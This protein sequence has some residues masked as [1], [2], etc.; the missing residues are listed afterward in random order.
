MSMSNLGN[1]LAALTSTN[2]SSTGFITSTS[3]DKT[4]SIGRGFHH[5]SLHGHSLHAEANV[6]EKVSIL[7]DSARE[8]AAVNLIDLREAAVSALDV[9]SEAAG[10]AYDDNNNNNSN[11][12]VRMWKSP[13]FMGGLLSQHNLSYERGMATSQQ[14]KEMDDEIEKMLRLIG[15]MVM[16]IPPKE[17]VQGDYGG[18]GN[19]HPIVLASLQIIEYLLRRYE[20]H[21]RPNTASMLLQT[22]LPL[23]VCYPTSNTATI[24]S[25]IVALVDLQ[26]LPTFT[27]LRPY[28]ARGAPPLSRAG[29]AK[30]VAKDDAL[31][32]VIA[33]IGKVGR[34]VCVVE[35]EEMRNEM[36]VDGQESGGGACVVRRG[37]STLISFSASILVEALYHQ[38]KSQEGSVKSGGVITTGVQESMVRKILPLV[39]AAL[40]SGAD[41]GDDAATMYCPEW[42]E[43]G[44]LLASTLA[45]LSPLNDTVK[46]ALCNSAAEGMPISSLVGG[47]KLSFNEVL[48][49]SSSLSVEEVDDATSAI[50]TLITIM[51]SSAVVDKK[52]KDDDDDWDYY[53]PM[54]PP[55]KNRRSNIVDYMGVDIASST[56]KILS[57]NSSSISVAIG[58]ILESIYGDSD[59]DDEDSSDHDILDRMA[60]FVASLVM[61]AFHR[62]EKEGKK[63][64]MA[65]DGKNK[66]KGDEKFKADRD[67]IMLLRLIKEP[68]LARLWNFNQS[69]LIAAVSV[70]LV[71]SFN[72]LHQGLSEKSSSAVLTE[73]YKS[74]LKALSEVNSSVRDQGVAYAINTIPEGRRQESRLALLLER[75]AASLQ[76][77]KSS[78]KKDSRV[79]EADNAVSSLLPLRVA[80]EHGDSK[81]RLDAVVRLNEQIYNESSDGSVD[82]DAEM[83]QAL[84]RRLCTEDDPEV[85]VVAGEILLSQLRVLKGNENGMDLDEPP[86]LLASLLDDLESLAKKA[87]SALLHWTFIG[88]D[89]TWS[90]LSSLEAFKQGGKSEQNSIVLESP[91]TSCIGICGVVAKLIGDEI[92]VESDMDAED[93]DLDQLTQLY[94]KLFL[95]VGAH[96]NGMTATDNDDS[97]LTTKVAEVASEELLS[98]AKDGSVSTSVEEF[99]TSS[100]IAEYVLEQ[101]YSKKSFDAPALLQNRFVWL[102]L[103][104]HSEL[105][106]KLSSRVDAAYRVID[107]IVFQMNSY[108]KESTKSESFEMEARFLLQNCDN[109]LPVLKS[110]DLDGFGN[111]I[112]KLASSSSPVSVESISKPAIASQ[113]TSNASKMNVAPDLVR[114]VHACLRSEASKEG[115]VHILSTA[116]AALEGGK[117]SNE[118]AIECIVPAFALLSHH[119]RE[120]RESLLEMLE[121]I[122]LA[123]KD[124][125]VSLIYDKVTDKSSPLRSSLLM[126]GVGTLPQA[127]S[128]IVLSFAQ[129][130]D[131]QSFFIKQCKFCALSEDNEIIDG[132]CQA[133]AVILSA[134]ERS[135][136]RVFPLA[137]R[138]ELG[139]RDLFQSFLRLNADEFV[140]NPS[141]CRL[142]D[143]VATM[144]K[145]VLV[146]TMQVEGDGMSIQ[147]SVGPSSSGRRS[148]SYSIGASDSFSV[149]EPYPASMLEAILEALGS[150]SSPLMLSDSVVQQ[151]VGRQSWINGVFPKL[152]SKSK[153]AVASALLT[154]RTQHENEIAG[155]ALLSLPMTAPDLVHLLDNL[156][157]SEDSQAAVVFI[158]DCVREKSDLGKVSDISKLSSK[159]FDQLL[160]LSS[161]DNNEGDSGGRDY[162]RVSILQTLLGI[163]QQY[164][165]QISDLSADDGKKRRKRSRS[166][167]DV[168][169][170]KSLATQ[171]NMLVGIVG[172]N[173]STINPLHSGRGRSLALS[174]L[175]CLCEESPSTVSS[176]LLPALMS[177]AGKH[178]SN[179]KG[180]PA[181]D[182]VGVDSRVLA[183]A[184]AAIIPAYCAHAKSA[185]LSLFSLIESFVGK[186]IVPENGNG[187]LRTHLIDPF[188]NAL[189]LL[190]TKEDSIDAIA[191]LA[192][193]VLALQ[194]FDLNNEAQTTG[195]DE[196]NSAKLNCHVLATSPSGIKV[197]IS[198]LLL[199]YAEQ[200]MAVICGASSFSTDESSS[201]LKACMSEVASLAL[202]GSNIGDNIPSSYSDCSVSQQRSILYLAICLL[203]MVRDVTGTN[204]VKRLLRKSQGD[205]AD[206]SLRLW[207]ELLQAHMHALRAHAKLAGEGELRRKEQKFWTAVPVAISECLENIQGLLPV[208]HFL[209]SVSSTLA[210]ESTDTYMRKKT[211]RLLADRVA[212]VSLD[213]AEASLFLEMVPELVAQVGTAQPSVASDDE[214]AVAALK[215]NI[216][217]QQG[218]LV[219]LESF[220]RSLCP[221]SEKSKLTSKAADAFVPALES[222]TKLFSGTA[223]SWSKE[224][225]EDD[226]EMLG[227]KDAEC[228]LLSSSS[229]C[230]ASLV[231]VLKARCLPLLPS[232][233]KP[234]ISSLK[235][236]NLLVENIE[237]QAESSESMLQLAILRLLETLAEN[238]PQFL[239]P[240]LPLIFSNNA[241]PS[242]ALR[243]GDHSLKEATER[244]ES[245]LASK[246]PIRQ[247]TPALSKALSN[248]L[249]NSDD[250]DSNDWEEACSILGVI[251]ASVGTS[252][253]SELPPVIG[254]IFN[255]L[256]AAYSYEGGDECKSRLLSDANKV[257]LSLV[258]KL[259]ESQLRQLYARLREWRGDIKEDDDNSEQSC[260]R[261]VAFW[262]LS[263]A[264]SKSLRSIFLPCLTS[265]LTDV[266]DELEIAVSLLCQRPKHDGSK[267]RR[268]DEDSD[269]DSSVDDNSE[270][271]PLQ[272]LLLCLESALKAD[273]HEG[274]DWTRGDDNQRYNMILSHLGKLLMVHVPKDLPVSSDLS[275]KEDAVTSSYQKLVEGQGTLEH[276][277]VAGCLTALATAAG[278]EQLWKPLNFAVLEACSHKRS[279]VRRAGIS[280][281]LSIIET[282]GEEYMV[283]LPECLPVLSELLEDGDEEI[284]GMAKECVRQGEELLGESLE[285]SLR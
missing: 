155:A 284:A 244:V 166:H 253:R 211:V 62:I 17:L 78:S 38:S 122:N 172:G 45:L 121:R 44:R 115:I 120:V 263:A 278:N 87:L 161:T 222:V 251:N 37:I 130:A 136:E 230:L 105:H 42:K 96:I 81:I 127:L 219:A 133:A 14:N 48:E 106:K 153:H 151:A 28:A 262:T 36:M 279:E 184:L 202:R 39:L 273:A 285:D 58:A 53:L 281:L 104:A 189:K 77:S 70:H 167:S 275:Q 123:K 24:F 178:S 22:F 270:V 57:K 231:A 283:L 80:L 63:A 187:K 181:R 41:N 194:A 74:I 66:K 246:T 102:A 97:D 223:A 52:T 198:L 165:S 56:Y 256:V 213:S 128:Q 236:V 259:S 27:F 129:P 268:V 49:N 221:A 4:Q 234:L 242:R 229:L 108:T 204:A 131:L 12:L 143:G 260:S 277:N 163:H 112:M 94:C 214:E 265:V 235:S 210:D 177:I 10:E 25:R 61:H 188:V 276:G 205:D 207:Q 195:E 88:T 21:A 118:V 261:R 67:V 1:Q 13:E 149:L 16:E 180:E 8:A 271:S 217:M 144:L 176:S 84:L 224:S 174:L 248:T 89:A 31:V 83:G 111:A 250:D 209:A 148:R 34:D 232:I 19:D 65:D 98:F 168:G 55:S 64:L 203:E 197:P 110:D 162:T 140:V 238:L 132:G 142:R 2:K 26:S 158:T 126:D 139:G 47:K 267:R 114:L 254:K 252:E 82:I 247:L 173:P 145:G 46:E 199:K 90:P 186:V 169:S 201:N 245:T 40:K 159:L 233:V 85:A 239:P 119:V 79:E 71:K 154:L 240:Y 269:S 160:A 117:V 86:L 75:N 280:C 274:G 33:N 6:K 141:I 190:P 257:L 137:K 182:G 101:C 255:V 92:N 116:K 20:I 107:L 124:E 228:Q 264:L 125:K 206:V 51:G 183:D 185:D 7:Y 196:A 147:I 76:V 212:E 200:L 35:A 29:L 237:F 59:E 91:L 156:D 175:T 135:G 227:I 11:A 5:S 171:A 146:N 109:Y 68:F 15:T 73:R 69:S 134:M 3:R 225:D 191:S 179:D 99:I 157:D 218:A 164:K 152:D 32:G 208:P 170:T 249:V 150:N 100:H 192:A 193:S 282:V 266:I 113:L 50:M 243:R 226:V 272:P 216:I 215:R 95:A 54:L 30:R 138:W 103:H 258:M 23:Q 93:G 241:L 72:D 60:P 43:W 18:G 220:V 9:L